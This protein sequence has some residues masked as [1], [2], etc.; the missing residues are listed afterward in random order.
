MLAAT[1]E[2]RVSCMPP[3]NSSYIRNSHY[4]SNASSLVPPD[5]IPLNYMNMYYQPRERIN[6]SGLRKVIA[7]SGICCAKTFGCYNETPLD[8]TMQ[9]K[10]IFASH[11]FTLSNPN[12]IQILDLDMTRQSKS[13]ITSD[14]LEQVKKKFSFS[15]TDLARLINLSRPTIYSYLKDKNTVP[16]NE[17]QNKIE[18]L[19]KYALQV[20]EIIPDCITDMRHFIK[21]PLFGGQSLFELIQK[22]D[23]IKSHLEILQKLYVKE[24]ASGR[25][26]AAGV[27]AKPMITLEDEVSVILYRE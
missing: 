24:K 20:Q 9:N 22:G 13:I 27:A 5:M 1:K 8:I 23:E 14:I 25:E 6:V 11:G 18:L 26:M 16:N 2:T 10:I 15:I 19:Y 17:I 12:D 7:M 21:R 4:Y 3:I